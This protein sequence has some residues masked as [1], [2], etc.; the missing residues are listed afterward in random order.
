MG[1]SDVF[2]STGAFV[3]DEIRIATTWDDV[4]PSGDN[5]PDK[6]FLGVPLNG[7][8][9]QKVAIVA[10]ELIALALEVVS[11]GAPARRFAA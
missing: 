4:V 7:Q 9:L 8:G 3:I 10:R 1:R 2:Y 6:E 5:T 11:A